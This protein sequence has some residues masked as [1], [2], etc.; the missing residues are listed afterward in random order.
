MIREQR[1]QIISSKDV[2]QITDEILGP[3]SLTP[4]TSFFSFYQTTHYSDGQRHIN[5]LDVS[6]IVTNQ[7]IAFAFR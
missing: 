1:K 2:Q 4:N 7:M 3:R 5:D 6:N